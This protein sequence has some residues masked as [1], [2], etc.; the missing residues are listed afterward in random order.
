MFI[1]TSSVSSLVGVGGVASDHV[2]Y[3]YVCI[4]TSSVSSLVGVGGC[5]LMGV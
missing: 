4:V 5:Y 1:V 2:T 3:V